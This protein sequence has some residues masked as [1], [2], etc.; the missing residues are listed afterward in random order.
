MKECKTFLKKIN[1]CLN[2]KLKPNTDL[3]EHL[4]NCKKCSLFYNFYLNTITHFKETLDNEISKTEDFNFD[5]I[6]NVYKIKKTAIDIKK[7][8]LKTALI[9][10]SLI[11]VFIT[12]FTSFN[13]FTQ[14]NDHIALSINNEHLSNFFEGSYLD[15]VNNT[16][17]S[18]VYN[19]EWFNYSA[20]PEMNFDEFFF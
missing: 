6:N 13:Y 3:A 18:E 12:A 10:A 14:N 15:D 1:N 9:A 17:T 16:Q 2:H 5:F 19:I 7:K 8:F 4:K 20:V 11:I